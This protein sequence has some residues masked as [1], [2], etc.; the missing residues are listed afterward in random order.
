MAVTGTTAEP[1][2][3]T[4]TRVAIVNRGEPAVRFLNA[5]REYA[6]ERDV[7]LT[8]IALYTDVDRHA[9][10]VRDADEA[11]RLGPASSPDPTTGST[12]LTYLNLEILR[13]A[14]VATRAEAVWV[15]WG[16]VAEDPAFAELVREL[17]LVFIGPSPESMRMVGD[18][19]AAKQLAEKVE[20]PVTPWS[21]GPVHTV[22]EAVQH[23]EHI[24]FPLVV[25]ATAGG[26]GRGIRMVNAPDE[27]PAAFES[28]RNEA[29]LAFGD[30]RVFMEW[31]VDGARHIEVQIAAD[32]HGGAWA[33]GVRDCSVQRRNQ[34][35][36]EESASTALPAETE[37]AIAAAGIRIAQATGYHGV[38]TI[39]FLYLPERDA[40]FFMEVNTRLQVEHTVTEA[41]TGVDLVKLQLDLARGLPLPAAAPPPAHGHAIE[42]RLNA[43]DPLQGFAPSPG[44]LVVFA[45]PQGPGMRVDSGVTEGDVIPPEYDSMI[46]KIIAWG[47]DRPEAI[48]RMRR[49]LGDTLVLVEGGTTNRAFLLSLLEQPDVVNGTIDTLWLDRTMASGGLTS[50]A[51]DDDAR[52]ALL[53]AAID[54]YRLQRDVERG[55]LFS[56]AL[57]GRPELLHMGSDTIDLQYAGRTYSFQVCEIAP[58]RYRVSVDDRDLDVGTLWLGRHQLRLRALGRDTKLVSMIHGETHMVES[59][60]ESFRIVRGDAGVVR[61]TS[62]GVV[63][64]VAVAAGDEISAGQTVM[65]VEAMKLES[66]VVAPVA[67]RVR[68]VL[69]GAN[70]QV[71]A[72]DPLLRIDVESD[73]DAAAAADDAVSFDVFPS[74]PP[75]TAVAVLRQRL[76]G[77][78][79]APSQSALLAGPWQ[80]ATDPAGIAAEDEAL[81]I[82]VDVCSVTQRV[83]D[84]DEQPGG[85]EASPED[86]LATF[87]RSVDRAEE[88]LPE[89]FLLRLRQVLARYGVTELERGPALDEAVARVY[90]AR[91]GLASNSPHVVALLRARLTA[92]DELRPAMGDGFADLLD[93]VTRVADGRFA[94]IAELAR[95]TR[96]RYV[97][98]GV[99]TQVRNDAFAEVERELAWLEQ[100]APDDPERSEHISSIIAIR[101]G[102]VTNLIE[103]AS[104]TD[105]LARATTLEAL[106]FRH[107]RQ[108]FLDRMTVV[109]DGVVRAQYVHPDGTFI[110]LVGAV[111]G[112]ADHDA[113][114][115]SV[116]AVV[117]DLPESAVVLEL[118]F[119]HDDALD[120]AATEEAARAALSSADFGRAVRRAVVTTHRRGAQTA[121]HFTYRHGENGFFEERLYRDLHPMIADRLELW[122]FSEFD[123]ERQPADGGVYVFRGRARSNPGDERIFALAEIHDLTPI[124]DDRG[125]VTAYPEIE[126]TFL[127]AVG[128]V[129]RAQ[130][131][132]NPR[133][134][135]LRN[136]VTLYV[137]PPWTLGEDVVRELARRLARSVRGS[138]LEQ[139]VVRAKVPGRDGELHDVVLQMTTPRS[140][141]FSLKVTTPS[142][143]PIA[144]QSTYD[145]SVLRLRRRG[146]IPPFELV[147]LLT[148]S[149]AT[150]S[151]FPVGEFTEYDLEATDDPAVRQRLVPVERPA[152][153]NVANLVAGVLVNRTA[154]HPEG[155]TRVVLLGDPGRSLGSLAEPECRRIV[156]ALDLAEELEVPVEWY[157]VSSG[158]KVAMDSGTENMDWTAAALRR[159]VEFTQAGHEINIV[160]SGVNVGAQSYFDAEATMLMHTR[161]V[162]I[163]LPGASMV[164]TGKQSL[165]VSGGVSAED[166]VGIG[167]FERVMG[168][169]G[170]A[171]YSAPDIETACQILFAHYEHTYVAPGERFPR[172]RP[173]S[174][175]TLRDVRESP[176]PVTEGSDFTTVGDVFSLDANPDRKK[177]FDIRAVMSAVTDSDAAPL[178][179]WARWRG[180][181]AATVWDAHIGGIPVE[182]IGIESKNL[183]RPGPLPADGPEIWTAGTL[184]PMSSKK[185]AR[186]INAASGVRPLVVLANLSG[187]DGSP[188]SMRMLQLEYGAEIGRAVVN[189]DGPIVFCVV[190]RYHGGAFVVFSKALNRQLEAA[191]VV[192]SKASVLGGAPAAAVV[193]SREVNARVQADPRVA[194][195]AARFEA[196]PP[197]Q[198]AVLRLQLAEITATVR[199]EKLGELAGEFDAV[200]TVER[201]RE[202]GSVDHVVAPEHLRPY[203]VDAL[204]RG[205][206]RTEGERRRGRHAH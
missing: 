22:E 173:N 7:P 98:E 56:T 165:D 204:E 117:R 9:W 99:I 26:G 160:V 179:R 101:P 100:H 89:R 37:R 174:D 75:G 175:P 84:D 138:G 58:A 53:L 196:A 123:L 76:L 112:W 192:G 40:F 13:E 31:K 108:R 81:Q 42:L 127:E 129:R 54:T 60:R 4:F 92:A 69:A 46:A 172:R 87:M 198:R 51:G 14:L 103:R 170:Q 21:G 68:E 61:A 63:V 169:N 19:I 44:R 93:A 181:E 134:R 3:R 55:H 49:A 128:A 52:A 203:L 137:Q 159:I 67:G 151:D 184:F 70:A 168:P 155:M 195:L 34:K 166:N 78:D 156:A 139:I 153:Q 171:Q 162:L 90:N 20:V 177:P 202:V 65:V 29:R 1:G 12:R 105:G 140:V 11:Y 145:N 36:M 35:V 17:G 10:F 82:F 176:H 115:A 71:D 201:A 86:H 158:A 114:I 74:D 178:E 25:K 122:R 80:P 73:D 148:P 95:A 2:V 180:A 33:V 102:V 107:Y 186:A 206:A 64:S 152:G 109:E 16:F 120:T 130:L 121:H 124:T 194:D 197:E 146:E 113:V 161:G 23:G 163:M 15:G 85:F 182:L 190:S 205:M 132:D 50:A 188:E 45:P 91:L 8:T 142:N 104:R 83:P 27:L 183:R 154:K 77:Y 119:W 79:T 48:A 57:R 143:E 32:E 193:F 189:F 167:G 116:A 144:P 131:D 164:L 125:R 187:F 41:T 30:E 72:G 150:R 96:F 111:G 94:A 66:A 18:K 185:V 110:Q 157:A 141:G 136:R 126:R 59:A 97:D 135:L 199:G 118:F 43:E 62:P 147:R 38:G 149:D 191:A 200:H 24:G 6:A 47:R 106:L 5:A 88:V 133:T 39:E 28:A